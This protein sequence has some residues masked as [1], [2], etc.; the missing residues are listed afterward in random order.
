VVS[1]GSGQA[2]SPYVAGVP[3]GTVTGVTG[4]LGSLDRVATIQP[5][6]DFT[7]LD[8]VGV[9]VSVERTAPRAPIEPTG[10]TP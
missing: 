5:Y 8:L 6:V 3:I 4:Q 1:F 10:A 9:V 2:G 7:A